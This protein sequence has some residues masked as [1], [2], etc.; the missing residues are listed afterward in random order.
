MNVKFAKVRPL[1]DEEE[2][3]I[4]MQIANDPESPELTEEELKQA[5][6]FKEMFPELAAKMEVEI[7]K[8]GRPKKEKTKTVI[9]VRLDHEV[10]DRYRA[11]GKGWQSQMN[12]DL[13]RA[14]GL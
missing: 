14:V 11:K 10:V 4:Q 3:E 8:R 2:S 6:P 5:R 7:P 12:Q 13:R 9:T 1:T